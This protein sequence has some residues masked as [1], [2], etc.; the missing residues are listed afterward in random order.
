MVTTAAELPEISEDRRA[1]ML[2]TSGTTNKP[3]G[4]VS[5]HKTIE[6]QITT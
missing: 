2:F 5:T 4:V 1:M 6:A 3:K